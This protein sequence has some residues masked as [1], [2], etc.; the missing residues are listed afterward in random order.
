[1]TLIN[2]KKK[3]NFKLVVCLIEDIEKFLN[4]SKMCLYDFA[5][6]INLVSDFQYKYEDITLTEFQLI[7]QYF[8]GACGK[9][10]RSDYKF[11]LI[12][13]LI[14]SPSSDVVDSE[15][16]NNFM[17]TMEMNRIHIRPAEME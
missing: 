16:S 8:C 15:I 1:M 13:H 6:N 7:D 3:I 12:G 2:I 14:Q 11:P 9:F 17:F 10:Y 5:N 4:E